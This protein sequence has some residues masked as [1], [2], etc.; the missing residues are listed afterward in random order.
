MVKF[1]P[2]TTYCSALALCWKGGWTVGWLVGTLA[3][4]QPVSHVVDQRGSGHDDDCATHESP[5]CGANN[6]PKGL[7]PYP[8]K[9]A[10]V[11][12][13]RGRRVSLSSNLTLFTTVII[14]DAAQ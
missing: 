9:R 10:P 1:S 11:L 4:G 8:P 7:C 13:T 5:G 12:R 14:M 3:R 6:I 2:E